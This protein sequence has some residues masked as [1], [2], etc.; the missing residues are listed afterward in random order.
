MFLG[1]KEGKGMAY[2]GFEDERMD[3]KEKDIFNLPR[4]GL[5]RNI[6]LRYPH[7]GIIEK[8]SHKWFREGGLCCSTLTIT[9][10]TVAINRD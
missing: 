2:I 1:L 9:I 7:N 3:D 5:V 10:K 6:T 4:S 8:R